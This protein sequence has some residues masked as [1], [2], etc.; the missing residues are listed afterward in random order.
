LDLALYPIRNCELFSNHWLENRLPLEPEWGEC[1]EAAFAALKEIMD[2]WSVE[3]DRLD[4]YDHEG[5][6]EHA[7]I[8]PVL[9]A[10][11]WRPIYQTY[12]RGRK[13]DYAL[14]ADEE[15][16][17]LAL[18]AGTKAPQFW[19]YPVILADAKAWHVPLDRPTTVNNRR[20]YP[21]E[22]I[23]WYLANSRLD[24]ALL[25]NG[26]LWRLIP[27]EHDVDQ[28]RFQTYLEADLPA[29]LKNWN[30]LPGVLQAVETPE[31]SDFLLF[32]LFLGPAGYLSLQ[33]RTPLVQRARQGSS[34]YRLGVGED[35]KER[36]FEA[37]RLCIEGF[38]HYRPNGL[39]A[40]NHLDLCRQQS[41]IIL[42]RLLFIM[43]AE[44]RRLLPYRVNKAY[45]SN[46]SLGRLRDEIASRLDLQ[47]AG[48][49]DDYSLEQ[50]DIWDDLL[51]LFDLVDGGRK[52]YGVPAYNGGLFSAKDHPFL[53]R[54]KMSDWHISRVI[55]Q[56]GR[57]RDAGHPKAGLYRVDY[58]DL[59]IQHL[60]N[61]YEG[62]LE[63]RPEV[64]DRPLVVVR[65]KSGVEERTW[66]ADR[67]VPRGFEPTG[68]SYTPGDVHL[69][70][71]KG[72]RRASG[73]Y[74][75]PN[76]IVDYL[77]EETLG[78]LC[79][80]ISAVLERE[81]VEWENR[82][83]DAS[84]EEQLEIAATIER[85]R[86]EYDDRVLNLK[87]LDPAMGSGHFLLKA[88]QYLAEEI[89]THPY[90][91]DHR[92]EGIEGDEPVISYWKRRVVERCLYGVD[93]NPLA[94]ELAKLALWLETVAVDRPLT[95]LDHHLRHGHSLVGAR[96]SK[97]GALPDTG[98][99]IE[100]GFQERWQTLLPALLKPLADILELPSDTA[101]QIKTKE[102][103]YR[104]RFEAVR[105]PFLQ[106]ADLW[107]AAFFLDRSNQ[108]DPHLYQQAL[109]TIGRKRSFNRMTKEPWFRLGLDRARAADA[110]F[111]HWEIEFP[112]VFFDA[113]GPKPNPGFDA[114]LGNPPYDVL[115]EK[116]TGHDPAQLKRFLAHEPIYGPS[117]RGKNNLYKLFICRALDL[118]ADGGRLG[119]IVPMALLGDDQA[120]GLR[121]AMLDRGAFYSI[122][123]FPQK[124]DPSRRV[125]PEA[126]L[127]TAAFTYVKSA[128]DALKQTP[129]KSRVHPGKTV[130]KDS[131]ALTLTTKDIPL[132]DASNLSIVSC[133]QADWDLAVRI[134][135]S[136][137]MGRLKDICQQ[138]QGEVNESIEK[139]KDVLSKDQ[140]DGPIVLRGSNVCLYAIRKASQG[141]T[142]YIKEKKFFQ[143][144]AL[145]AKAYHTKKRRVGFQR[146]SPQNNYRRI[147]A[148]E[149]QAGNYC[150]DTISYVPE[151][152]CKVPFEFILGVLNSKL[153]DWYFRLG[154][155]NSKVNEY[156][157]NNLPC[158]P[159]LVKPDK[160]DMQIQTEAIVALNEGDF[161]G[162]FEVIR[163][164]LEVPPFGAAALGLM[165]EAV[166]R[167]TAVEAARGEISR[168]ERSRLA[169]EAQ[170][171]Q[172]LIDRMLYAM[173]GLS[174][175]EAA[176]LE[177]RLSR[178]L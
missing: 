173:A 1:R 111:F 98:E 128:D 25:T 20:E 86:S 127:S 168:S 69:L 17:N 55:D 104:T 5:S 112:E 95:F 139:E 138:F 16:L 108:P 84:A 148:A 38:L 109:L 100:V 114:V 42:Y 48:R 88:C 116:E 164:C 70:T 7:F 147:I 175:A 117:R 92:L 110:A 107:C 140:M 174:E 93:Q 122:E 19:D 166:R 131:P 57:A 13:P 3:K 8:Q 125:F 83:T 129:F 132:Y 81:I 97:L 105:K 6:L 30:D 152:H 58:R 45:T 29:I 169:P 10:L 63:L 61:I 2:I 141:E 165:V 62:L 59:Q 21:P 144:K 47:A 26:R 137:R 34:E 33:G 64:V 32:F 9:K 143:G 160:L 78:P 135:T 85:L 136:G 120:A 106:I 96:V 56:L 178:M 50:T 28:P 89:A 23:E 68:V 172:D 74:Y 18:K 80:R 156:Q 157:F 161:T 41:F 53:T 118:M 133:S 170:P 91:G 75:T 35:I 36:V 39:K 99:L 102:K 51:I 162:A 167:I 54:M 126:K 154:S 40:E 146:S 12:L 14:F 123:A 145:T 79:R 94:V 66:P 22:Q 87:V 43:Y 76:H 52:T 44:D 77:V 15:A 153:A 113:A 71:E 37:L 176:G 159:I 158:P 124:D 27:R 130:E 82:S 60:G 119:F 73:S 65:K 149:I 134:M 4:H 24:Y 121:Q 11:G 31:F 142:Y 151:I 49:Y 171:Y 101:A 177:E 150:F 90:T 72:E 67:A 163:P 115:S 103:L 46:R 155:T